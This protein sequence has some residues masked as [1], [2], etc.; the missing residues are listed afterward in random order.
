M[1]VSDLALL[2]YPTMAPMKK[3]T[4]ITVPVKTR[5]EKIKK[6]ISGAAGF[7]DRV[8]KMLGNTLLCTVGT[9]KVDRHPF[10]ERFVA[11]IEQV[12]AAEHKRLAAEIS[13]QTAA[14]DALAPAKATREQTLEAAKGA[15]DEKGAALEEAKKAV[16]EASSSLKEAE[17]AVKEAKKAQKSGD[18]EIEG[19]TAKKT[20]LETV[21]S[22]SLAPVIAEDCED[23]PA[24][25]KAVLGT[26][27][28]FSFDS[29]L[30][31]TS[32]QVLE[33][34]AAERGGFDATCLEQLKEA[35]TTTIA[36]FNEEISALLPGKEERQGV[37]DQAE[38]AAQAA[39]TTLN[40]LKEA[41]AAAKE[42]KNAAD[43]E[44]KAAADSLSNFLPELKATGDGL[45]GAKKALKDFESGPQS[46]FAEL[47]D[48]QEGQ[49][50]QSAYYEK[51]DGLKCDK[52]IIDACREA[53]KGDGRVNAD[54][55][56]NVFA[57]IADGN[58][59]TRVERWTLCYCMT[60]FKWTEE[61]DDWITDACAKVPQG[62]PSKKPRKSGKSYYEVVDGVRLDRSIVDLCRAAVEREESGGRVSQADAESVWAKAAD[63]KG[64]TK[65]EKWTLRYCLANFKFAQD[66]HDYIDAQ[67]KALDAP[68]PAA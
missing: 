23:K 44:K 37:V 66:A 17:G 7:P 40:G 18:E 35:F 52:A 8:K 48:L 26:A 13:S 56:K 14:F 21:M 60:E 38:A 6:A 46:A 9:N 11:M 39:Q 62:R 22:D 67:V 53:L 55:A 68:A 16:S 54:D 58:K 15:A 1:S 49:F 31:N 50:K 57:K 28:A 25:V 33:R 41:A 29:S 5:C 43:A 27:A 42:A 59:V 19:L 30:I 4:K 61:A 2:S 45:D 3:A 36:K 32:T 20:K 24:K 63:G 51:V 12:V 64:V 47:K 34:A 65:T 10:N